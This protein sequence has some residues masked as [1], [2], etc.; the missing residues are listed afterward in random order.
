MYQLLLASPD[1]ALAVVRTEA[2]AL[3]FLAVGQRNSAPP[4]DDTIQ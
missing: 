1:D 2:E 4:P 3:E